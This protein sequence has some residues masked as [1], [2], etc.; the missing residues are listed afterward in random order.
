MNMSDLEADLQ[1]A[2]ARVAQLEKEKAELIEERDL[3]RERLSYLLRSD[4][5]SKYDLKDITGF[6][7]HD[8]DDLDKEVAAVDALRG[9]I[10]EL[11]E[12]LEARVPIMP[13]DALLSPL[14]ICDR[15]ACDTCYPECMHTKDLRHAKHFEASECR[16]LFVEQEAI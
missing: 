9:R 13:A 6:Y 11:E 4:T 1:I 15:R 7:V 14:F 3:L 12:Q 10:I 5:I 8:I 16:N 2:N